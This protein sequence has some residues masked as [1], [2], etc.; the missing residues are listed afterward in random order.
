M[1]PNRGHSVCALSGGWRPHETGE[2]KAGKCIEVMIRRVKNRCVRWFGE[3]VEQKRWNAIDRILRDE[4]PPDTHR[5]EGAFERLQAAYPSNRGDLYTYDD[6]SLYERALQRALRILRLS[7]LEEY[8]RSVLDIG[9]GDGVL[10]AILKNYGHSVRLTDMED[11]RSRVGRQV[12]FHRADVTKGLPFEDATFDL[13]V[14]FNSFEHF[15]DP[16]AAFNEAL[17][18]TK[19]GGQLYFDFNPLY[20][21]AWGLHA[22]RSL[23][24]PYSQF[25][26]SGDFIDAQLERLGISDLGGTRTT[27]QFL[28]EWKSVQFE[29]V[30]R[31][32]GALVKECEWVCDASQLGIVLEFPEAFRGRG[33]TVDDLVRCGNSVTITKCF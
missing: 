19:P 30:W 13:A 5:S 12:E 32:G 23:Y 7:G 2:G 18:V 22:Y 3:R 1:R 11:W 25:L 33:L 10:G 17:R 20:C 24:M 29:E 15:P 26:F 9:A 16:R 27:L 8:G 6:F 21:S 14:S 28:N 31:E 4:R